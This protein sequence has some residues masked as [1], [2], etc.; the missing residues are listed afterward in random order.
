MWDERTV[1]SILFSRREVIVR[2][3]AEDYRYI[4]H[5][6]G[7]VYIIVRPGVHDEVWRAIAKFGNKDELI[8]S[9]ADELLGL[10]RRHYGPETEGYTEMLMDKLGK[11][12]S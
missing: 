5:H 10:I 11:K 7:S 3:E 8:A 12:Y 9:S 6:W 1:A 2:T 4:R